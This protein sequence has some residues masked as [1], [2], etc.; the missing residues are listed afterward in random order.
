MAGMMKI[1][2]VS[3]APLF[4]SACAAA[5]VGEQVST[6]VPGK[7]TAYVVSHDL[8]GHARSQLK[9]WKKRLKDGV[10]FFVVDGT[11]ASF[12]AFAA[13]NKPNSCYTKDARMGFHG[14]TAFGVFPTPRAIE[15]S[16][17]LATLLPP[18]LESWFLQSGLMYMPMGLGQDLLYE[19]LKRIYPEGECP[20]DVLAVI[21]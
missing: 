1:L 13:L 8:G 10:E 7:G 19:D 18:P 6:D 21:A 20:E 16:K 4:L 12:C 9:R 14:A 2:A 3:L 11:C 17:K 5:H 15:T